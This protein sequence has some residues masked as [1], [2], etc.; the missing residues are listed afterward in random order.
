MLQT[1]YLYNVM[2]NFRCIFNMDAGSEIDITKVLERDIV[3]NVQKNGMMG[4]YCHA[5]KPF[6]EFN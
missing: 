2:F 5:L 3:I 6:G 1:R 4:R